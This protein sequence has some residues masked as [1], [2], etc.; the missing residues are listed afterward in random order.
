MNRPGVSLSCQQNQVTPRSSKTKAGLSLP[1]MLGNLEYSAYQVAWWALR[2]FK[3]MDTDVSLATKPPLLPWTLFCEVFSSPS[4]RSQEVQCVRCCQVAS[5]CWAM[6]SP[7]SRHCCVTS[8]C[9]M[10]S[11]LPLLSHMD[12][13]TGSLSRG[14]RRESLS[15]VCIQWRSPE[16][17]L[18]L[19]ENVFLFCV[20]FS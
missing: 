8:R 6:L 3:E 1:L 7:K 14:T 15:A 16:R 20:T 13:T 9:H 18:Q 10:S 5:V 11:L 4:C 19:M 12:S 17:I 2:W